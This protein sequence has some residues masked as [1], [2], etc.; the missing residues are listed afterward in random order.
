MESKLATKSPGGFS[1]V[2][3]LV[4]VAISILLMVLVTPTISSVMNSQR[5]TDTGSR[6]AAL[7]ERGRMHA[8]VRHRIVGVRFFENPTNS[9][10]FTAA[11]LV[12]LV[13]DSA[14]PQTL[15]TNAL[16]RLFRFSEPVVLSQGHSSLL[17]TDSSAG[18][19]TANVPGEGIRS[20]RDF[21]IFPDGSTSLSNFATNP[22]LGVLTR[23]DASEDPKNPLVISLD[24]LTCRISIYRK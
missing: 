5:I 13:P 6:L 24:P 19:G 10:E 15:H 1:L 22:N 16:S 17:A 12:E 3:L 4:V 23:G 14:A 8:T 20:Y 2:E 21:L 9:A 11:D 18:I 7:I